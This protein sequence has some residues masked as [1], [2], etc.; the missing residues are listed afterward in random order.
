V[1]PL[2]S[3]HC[4][5]LTSQS[6]LLEL[7]NYHV[8]GRILF[9]VPYFA[10][11]HPGRT[12]TTF[13]FFSGIVEVM[14]ALG[15]SYLATPT[16]DASR[17]KLGDGLLKASLIC[18]LGVISIFCVIAG[19]F[20]RR[21]VRAGITSRKVQGPLWTMYTSMTLIFIRTIYRIVEHFGTSHIPANPSPDWDPISLSPIVRYEWFFWVFEA[22][23]MLINT[24]MWNY[25][26]PRRY[27]PEDYHVY[28]AQ[29][30]QTELKGPGWKDDMPW[31]WTFIDPCGLTASLMGG[32]SKKQKPFWETNG[33][34]NIPLIKVASKGTA[35]K[36]K[37][38]NGMYV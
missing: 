35:N 36:S 2:I 15:V 1:S 18:Q 9:Y 11:L 28:L 19:I 25:R 29:D 27:L 14:N 24:V 4:L 17:K 23:L 10:P 34:E 16:S 7:A 3:T 8:L 32:R 13:G 33:Y 31:F 30:G 20:H 26:H 5:V 6:P 38:L 12:L 37:A 22:S 21:C